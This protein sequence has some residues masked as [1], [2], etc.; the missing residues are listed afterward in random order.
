MGWALFGF[1]AKVSA[2]CQKQRI[3]R[4]AESFYKRGQSATL[5]HLRQSSVPGVNTMAPPLAGSMKMPFREQVLWLDLRRSSRPICACLWRRWISAKHGSTAIFS[6]PC[7][8]FSSR[9]GH[10]AEIAVFAAAIAFSA[11][12]RSGFHR[13]IVLY[14]VVPRV[15]RWMELARPTFSRRSRRGRFCWWTC[16]ATDTTIPAPPAFAARSALSP[17]TSL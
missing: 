4:S 3:L 11:L 10:V 13:N 6:C 8:W 2:C 17:I 5:A 14:R 9:R 12:S 16:A 1:S 15:F 7:S